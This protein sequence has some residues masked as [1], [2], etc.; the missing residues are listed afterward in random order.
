MVVSCPAVLMQLLYHNPRT[1]GQ[2]KGSQRDTR[3]A[4]WTIPLGFPV[5]GMW[6]DYSDG[7]DVNA[8]DRSPSGQYL[9]TADDHG[10]VGL[11]S[12]LPYLS[13]DDSQHYSHEM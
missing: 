6:P 12:C 9:L 5:M 1:G 7:T 3:W 13:S 11:V 4:T 10:K 2:V 8:C